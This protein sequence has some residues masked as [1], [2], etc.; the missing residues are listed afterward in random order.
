MKWREGK[1][2]CL[3]FLRASLLDFMPSS[4]QKAFTINYNCRKVTNTS[5]RKM[6]SFCSTHLENDRLAFRLRCFRENRVHDVEKL[7]PRKLGRRIAIEIID[8]IVQKEICACG[9]KS[10]GKF[11]TL[12]RWHS[13]SL[14]SLR[15]DSRDAC[16]LF[17]FP[18]K[19]NPQ[20]G[21][22]DRNNFL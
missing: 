20:K 18:L 15:C 13:R 1:F 21:F 11:M 22:L 10:V 9:E 6:L 17:R 2:F 16:K 19:L 12:S 14:Q 8:K 3:L 7:F 4:A 5:M